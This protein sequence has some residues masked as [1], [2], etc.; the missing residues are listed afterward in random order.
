VANPESCAS[1]QTLTLGSGQTMLNFQA[2]LRRAID[3]VDGTCSGTGTTPEL[4]YRLPLAQ[5]A[6]VT[7][8][9][10]KAAGQGTSDPV[11]FVRRGDC[12]AGVELACAD[13]TFSN[14]T[15]TVTLYGQ[16]P[17]DLFVF[18][19]AWS[20]TNAVLTD[21]SVVLAPPTPP[22]AND[23][24]A[25]PQ[26]LTFT[27][28]EATATGSFVLATNGNAAADPSPSCS[29]AARSTGRDLVY[30]Y[31]LTQPQDVRLEVR[32][33]T[34]N[35]ITP[36][37]YVR[38]LADCASTATTA[39]LACSAGTSTAVLTRL[40]NQPAGDYALWVD[41][42]TAEDVGFTLS[43]ALLPPT[44]PPTNDTCATPTPLTFTSGV[45]ST[46]GQTLAATNDYTTLACT[47]MAGALG[48]DVVYAVTVPTPGPF[49]VV[50][51]SQSSDW[52]PV[53]SL[54]ATCPTS[55]DLDCTTG[56]VGGVAGALVASADAGTH[57]VFV[58]GQADGGF[59]RLDGR[60]GAPPNDTCATA[61]PLV[62][63]TP[64]V[65]NSVLDH[66]R[67]A[68]NDFTS[69]CSF[70][71]AFAG[72]DLVYSFTPATSGTVTLRAWPDSNFDVAI[73]VFTGTCGALT[74][75]DVEDVGAR[76]GPETMPLTVTAGTTYYVVVDGYGY[77][78][79]SEGFFRLEVR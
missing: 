2:D 72:K 39:E 51:A 63:S 64:T 42:T 55:G 7:L 34:A 22:P 17:G 38:P 19:E 37:V 28:G 74:C 41:S 69:G 56:R 24:C 8:S 5:A 12:D 29:S 16:Q 73:A 67:L 65:D 18:V 43:V 36:V 68:V 33:T 70:T 32:P 20:S 26:L 78:T 3:D 25:T 48:R 60:L 77:T 6:D 59:F 23:T 54:S 9:A 31:T 40:V 76:G 71:T 79:P 14:G 46:T 27:N 15:E 4:V 30:R 61:T 57:Y 66:T 35:T 53:A 45:F 13:E 49:S 50:V 75:V 10:A 11:L 1:A 58:D 52:A 44:L 47:S 21:V 62:L